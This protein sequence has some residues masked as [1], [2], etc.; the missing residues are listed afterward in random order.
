MAYKEYDQAAKELAK[1]TGQPV[2]RAQ[3]AVDEI[4]EGITRGSIRQKISCAEARTEFFTMA[5]L[6]FVDGGNP[7]MPIDTEVGAHIAVCPTKE[8]QAL[9]RAYFTEI[10]NSLPEN[11]ERISVFL[12]QLKKNSFVGN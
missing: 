1:S 8:C 3:A 11:T 12:N 4:R 9:S 5:Y 6:V 2:D 7:R 10:K